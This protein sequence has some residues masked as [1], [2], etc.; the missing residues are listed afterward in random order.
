YK[1]GIPRTIGYPDGT[2][3]HLVVDDF[4]QISSITNQ[5]GNKTSYTYDAVGRLTKITYPSGW[6]PE[7]F[8]YAYAGAERGLGAGHWRRTVSQGDARH[9]TYYDALLR[10]VLTDTYI[11]GNSS[12]HISARKAYNWKGLTTFASWPVT[13]SPSRS[14]ITAGTTTTYDALGRVTHVSQPSELGNLTTTTAY[15]GGARKKVTDP[16]GH[17]TTTSYQVF[18]APSYKAVTKVQAPEGIVQTITRNIYGNPTAITQSGPDGQGGTVSVAK[19]LYYNAQHRLCRS[20]EPE[21]GS[22][23]MGYDAAGN[24]TWSAEGLTVGGSGCGS[25]PASRTVRGYD[26]MNRLTT[27][28]YPDGQGNSTT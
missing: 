17:A 14:A 10:P 12:S 23:L 9:V 1:R 3:Q 11:A 5:A 19:H 2:S 21:T 6:N 24:L 4:G 25:K 8:A 15:L 26:A 20:T 13:G 18:D 7:T 28:S 27:V 22:T 16:A